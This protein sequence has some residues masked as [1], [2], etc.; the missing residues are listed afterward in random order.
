[1]QPQYSAS[2][3][4]MRQTGRV[5]KRRKT[6]PFR[7]RRKNRKNTFGYYLMRRAP[8]NLL[9][10]LEQLFADGQA[11]WT[12]QFGAAPGAR[13]PAADE[14]GWEVKSCDSTDI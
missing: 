3:R 14:Q 10:Q 8:I 9:T 2:G 1:M 5:E 12:A 4:G 13:K 6:R 11:V 7:A